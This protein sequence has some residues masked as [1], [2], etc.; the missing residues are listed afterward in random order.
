MV[1]PLATFL[2]LSISSAFSPGPNNITCMALGQQFGFKKSI[3]YILGIVSGYT[4]LLT[5]ISLFHTFIARYI[6]TNLLGI[7][8]ATYL[9]Y[10]AWGLLQTSSK[11]QNN[12]TVES[13]FFIAAFLFQFIN[14]KGVFFGIAL[15]SSFAFPYAESM[16]T[17]III[18]I[19]AF[20]TFC[21]V[22]VWAT[23]GFLLQRFLN[24][25]QKVFNIFMALLLVY[26]AFIVS[27]IDRF[28]IK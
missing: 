19:L 9:C 17:S 28:F 8:G 24:H 13:N 2:T 20:L 3:P 5:M 23:F 7:L 14:P 10:L 18:G 4:V 12:N 1:F 25:H 27:G 11:K 26:S 16:P 21:S 15:I 22:S 6:P